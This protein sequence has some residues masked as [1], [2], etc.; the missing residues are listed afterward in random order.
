MFSTCHVPFLFTNMSDKMKKETM[1]S[2]GSIQVLEAVVTVDF[3]LKEH[4][5]V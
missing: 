2:S 4:G 3:L 5:T 1:N